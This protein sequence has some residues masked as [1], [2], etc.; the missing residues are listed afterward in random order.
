MLNI[1]IDILISAGPDT[2]SIVLN[3]LAVLFLLGKSLSSPKHTRNP[4]IVL[5]AG[6]FLLIWS[7]L[8]LHAHHYARDRQRD[9]YV[10]LVKP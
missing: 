5:L 7:D 10:R 6:L 3:S 9:L 8:P 1:A 4:T 2:L